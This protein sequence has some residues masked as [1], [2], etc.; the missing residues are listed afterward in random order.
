MLLAGITLAQNYASQAALEADIQGQLDTIYGAGNVTVD[1][2]TNPG[3]LTF[4]NVNAG[5]AGP[6]AIAI[7]NT[8][9][10]AQAAGFANSAGAAGNYHYPSSRT[11]F[12]AASLDSRYGD[13]A[14]DGAQQKLAAFI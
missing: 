7:S 10:N 6:N 9:V 2:T 14:R 11:Q 1:S 3:F 5:G 4:I 8:D 13:I 12:H